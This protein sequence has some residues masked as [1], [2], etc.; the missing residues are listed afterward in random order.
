MK[1]SSKMNRRDFLSWLGKGLLGASG[2]LGISSAWG[3][4]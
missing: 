1:Q 3:A 2:L 4:S